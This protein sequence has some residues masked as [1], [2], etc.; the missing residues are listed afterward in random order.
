[1]EE[2]II[3][4]KDPQFLPPSV[5]VVKEIHILLGQQAN[6]YQKQIDLNEKLSV[7]PQ[8]KIMGLLL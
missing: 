4:D 1:L 7:L 8:K 6:L 5:F 3:E 2:Y